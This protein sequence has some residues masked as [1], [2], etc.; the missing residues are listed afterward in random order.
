MPPESARCAVAFAPGHVTGLFDPR[1]A[2]TDPRARGSVGAG[3]VLELGAHAVARWEPRG[4]HRVTVR[5]E[6]DGP[7]PI[8][9]EVARR[10]VRPVGGRLSVRI[11]HDLPVGQG[12][13]MSAAGALATGL[14]VA[15][16]TGV[17]RRRAVEVAHL[18]EL[19]GG[20]GLGG[21]AAI[22]R[23]GIE[24]RRAPGVPPWGRVRHTASSA[25]LL[26]G[27]VGPPIPSPAVLGDPRRMARVHRA[28]AGLR[29]LGTAPS[30]AALLRASERFTDE[31]GLAPAPLVRLVRGLRRDGAPAA[32]AMFGSSFFAALPD[33]EVARRA[34]ERLAR[35]RVR[36]V[37]VRPDRRGARLVPSRSA[38]AW[39]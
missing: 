1:L 31:V 12:F 8:S 15:A 20:G 23:G 29:G 3:V 32:Q 13:G 5:R 14:A 28:A 17:P 25:R 37:V 22:L 24:V 7:T 21:V 38:A 35:S 18:A 36:A 39:A 9:T 27:V 2:A 4:P 19:Y 30:L 16:V 34:V 11:R 6:P 26:V 33:A 10:L